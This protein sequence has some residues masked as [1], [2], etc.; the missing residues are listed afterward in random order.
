M[1]VVDTRKTTPLHRLWERAAVRHGGAYNH[2]FALFD[3]VLIKENH[4][5][6]AGGLRSAIQRAKR[7][8]HHLMGI[9]V[10]VETLEQLREALALGVDA[11]LLDNM[12]DEE[13]QEAARICSGR[14]RSEASGNLDAT[15]IQRL[16]RYKDRPDQVSVGGLIHQA[17]WVDLSLRLTQGE[18]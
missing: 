3:G 2:R 14:A 17:R 13:L 1:R 4:I 7:Q 6:A 5:M 12:S 16:A 10:E 8:R 9:Q 11:V 15:R 18:D